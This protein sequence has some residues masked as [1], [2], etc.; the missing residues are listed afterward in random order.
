MLTGL[1]MSDLRSRY[2]KLKACGSRAGDRANLGSLERRKRAWGT[3]RIRGI[4]MELCDEKH[5]VND[6]LITLNR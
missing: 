2:R 6:L 1:R 5:C 4:W 3:W